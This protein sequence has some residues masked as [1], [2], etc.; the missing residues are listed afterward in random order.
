MKLEKGFKVDRFGEE[1]GSFMAAADASFNQRS[2]PPDALN[3]C[4]DPNRPCKPKDHPWSYHV[5]EVVR[6]FVVMGGP[7]APAFEQ[8]GMVSTYGA[9]GTTN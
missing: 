1:T 9:F 8:P 5:Y 2:L 7:I 4:P 6:E 3:V